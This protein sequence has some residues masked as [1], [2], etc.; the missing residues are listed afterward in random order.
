MMNLLEILDASIDL[1]WVKE[2]STRVAAFSVNDIQYQLQFEPAVVLPKKLGDLS[3]Y[4]VS[5]L[6]L[7]I[8]GDAAYSS[9]GTSD[10]PLS[11]YGVVLN[12]ITEYVR[13]G[14]FQCDGLIFTA[15]NRHSRDQQNHESKVRI[16]KFLA[17][18]FAKKTGWT[19]F[20][21]KRD[22]AH[23]FLVMKEDLDLSDTRFVDVQEELRNISR[24][25]PMPSLNRKQN[26]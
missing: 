14:D 20:D 12:A 6:L 17:E 15:E 9:A 3:I 1:V 16:Y 2:K 13:S 25:Q 5:F 21:S 7:G 26:V 4:E 23:E 19:L 8:K 22:G 11:V 10:A 18:R 24:N